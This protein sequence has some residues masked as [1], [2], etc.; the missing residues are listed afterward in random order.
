MRHEPALEAD[1]DVTFIAS[2]DH[3]DPFGQRVS[4]GLKPRAHIEP[5]AM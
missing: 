4:I 1:L 3:T 5:F 2:P